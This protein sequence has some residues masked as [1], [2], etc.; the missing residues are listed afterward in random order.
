MPTNPITNQLTITVTGVITTSTPIDVTV[1]VPIEGAP[2]TPTPTPPP[3]PNPDTELLSVEI[4]YAG[5]AYDFFEEQGEDIGVY[6]DPQYRFVQK[7][8]RV[9]HPE[10][11][12][13]AVQFRR[14]ETTN[15][16]EIVFELGDTTT[17]ATAY[18]TTNYTVNIYRGP[19]LVDTLTIPEHYWYSRWRWNPTPRPITTS[20]AQLQADGLIPRFDPALALNR[21]YAPTRVYTP[22]GLAGLTAYGPTTG[23]RDE[24]GLVTEAQAEYLSG[25]AGP[26]SL[27]AQAEASGT[28]PWHYRDENN[29]GNPGALY[30]FTAHTNA[31]VYYPATIPTIGSPVTPDTAHEPPLAYVPFLL[32]GDPYYLEELQF[33]ATFNVICAVPSQRANFCIGFALRAH[34]WA[35]RVLAECARVTPEVVPVWLKPRAYWQTWLD[36]EREWMLSRYVNPTA[37]PFTEVPYKDFHFMVDAQGSPATTTLPAGTYNSTWM[38]DYEAVV[39]GHVVQMGYP[40]WRPILEWKLAN[41]VARTN[42]TSGWARA[43]TTPYTMVLR[44]TDKSPYAKDW[45]AVWDL[46]VQL[47][48]PEFTNFDDPDVIPPGASLTYASYTMSALAL[49]ALQGIEGAADCCIWLTDQIK[50]NSTSNNYIDRKWSM[51]ATERV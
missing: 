34:A 49:A 44:E 30:D 16:E 8:T 42:G 36:Q 12:A 5:G 41:T 15:R 1:V 45:P 24:I 4:G 37:S 3:N 32:T 35:L 47:Q 48:P 51:T 31:T 9:T 6:A 14:D 2:P 21:P 11:L 26:E 38:E 50:T 18:N 10:L 20:I 33:A 17:T 22:M 28:L 27:L 29:G 19:V 46:N 39:L 13:F 25:V 43:K 40:D 7:N 23:E